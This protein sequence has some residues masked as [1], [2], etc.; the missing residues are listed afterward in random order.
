LF[1]V[2]IM[3]INVMAGVPGFRGSG[4]PGFGSRFSVHGAGSAAGEK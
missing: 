3:E 4:V 1:Y 2:I